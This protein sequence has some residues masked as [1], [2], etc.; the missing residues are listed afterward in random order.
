MRLIDAHCHIDLYPDYREVIEAS[1]R[2]GI[3][4]IAVTNTPSV[5]RACAALARGRKYIRAA[6]GLHPELASERYRELDL[7]TEILPE[8]RYIGEV[9]LDYVTPDAQNRARQRRVFQSVLDEC[10]PFGDKVLT[11]HS[12]RAALEVVDMVGAAYPGTVILH[13]FTGAHAV[14]DR[15]LANGCYFSVNTA[16]CASDAGRRIVAAIPRHRILTESD[17]PFVKVNGRPARPADAALTIAGVAAVWNVA[18]DDVAGIVYQNFRTMLAP[19][20]SR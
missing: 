1:E 13:W 6:V 15:A 3:Y 5:F 7:L 11:V 14:L 9:G 2:A 17:G 12:R 16:M 18:P 19:I 8:T 20:S 10:A 4:T